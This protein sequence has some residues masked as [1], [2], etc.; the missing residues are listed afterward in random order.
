[1]SYMNSIINN[2][3]NTV[4]Y[5]VVLFSLFV[6]L[7]LSIMFFSLRLFNIIPHSKKEIL[8][9]L[10]LI[11]IFAINISLIFKIKN[12]F[13]KIQV[14][15]YI[16]YSILLF[17][18]VA[19]TKNIVTIQWYYCLIIIIAFTMYQYLTIILNTIILLLI[20]ILIYISYSYLPIYDKLII[21]FSFLTCFSISLIINYFLEKFA[22]ESY[23][24]R[25]LLEKLSLFDYLTEAYNRRAFFKFSNILINDAKREKRKLSILMIDID[26]FKKINDT[27]GHDIGDKVLKTF[28]K[29]IKQNI[30]ENDLFARIGGEEFVILTKIDNKEQLFTFAQKISKLTKELKIFTKGKNI[31]FTISIGGYI[32]DPSKE[33]LDYALK[34]ADEALYKAKEKRDSI[35]IFEG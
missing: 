17:L 29:M 19:F 35:V 24:K 16:I 20:F 10:L 25:E 23:L 4:R 26:Y 31:Q 2:S 34:K 12:N 32:F 1:M 13:T 22:F 21:T 9:I 14:L 3:L 11:F 6:S 28:V 33:T 30:R 15:F 27:Y 5:K 7:A 8:L 18:L